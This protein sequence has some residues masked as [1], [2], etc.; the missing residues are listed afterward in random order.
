MLDRLGRR[1]IF[2]VGNRVVVFIIVVLIVYEWL[3]AIL[4]CLMDAT[5]LCQVIRPGK[6]FVAVWARVGALLGVS[7]HM[8]FQML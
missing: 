3:M 1:V 8:S 7:P 6:R 4:L 5:V 2:V